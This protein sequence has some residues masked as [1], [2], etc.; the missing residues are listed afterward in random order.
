MGTIIILIIRMRKLRQELGELL[1]VT[2]VVEPGLESRQSDPKAALPI[3]ISIYSQVHSKYCDSLTL[4]L[5]I[6]N[7][8]NT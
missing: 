1:K 3:Y 2:Q 7:A 4:L 5:C 8:W 6:P